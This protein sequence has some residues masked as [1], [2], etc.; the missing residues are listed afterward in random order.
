[1][2]KISISLSQPKFYFRDT[3]S[4]DV[5]CCF[6][7]QEWVYYFYLFLVFMGS[8]YFLM[9]IYVIYALNTMNILLNVL[10]ST[11]SPVAR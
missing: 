10:L 3:E 8:Q 2:F 9:T 5:S 6:S 7:V 11:V 1:M 4:T